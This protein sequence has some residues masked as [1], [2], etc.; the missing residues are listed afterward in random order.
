MRATRSQFVAIGGNDVYRTDIS[1]YAKKNGDRLIPYPDR[2]KHFVAKVFIQDSRVPLDTH[3][4]EM[5]ETLCF[6]RLRSE[7]W[8]IVA[9]R[10]RILR[11]EATVLKKKYLM[12]SDDQFL[13]QK[14]S[15]RKTVTIYHPKIPQ[16]S[17][18]LYSQLITCQ[19]KNHGKTRNIALRVAK[20]QERLRNLG[21][22]LP[23]VPTFKV[24]HF[25]WTINFMEFLEVTSN[26]IYNYVVL[27][28]SYYT[29]LYFGLKKKTE[30]SD[31]SDS[32]MDTN[33]TAL[34]NESQLPLSSPAL[35]KSASASHLLEEELD[36]EPGEL[37][38]EVNRAEMIEGAVHV[39]QK[40]KPGN[41]RKRASVE[42]IQGR[43]T[44]P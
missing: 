28:T 3:L 33:I 18:R 29:V 2:G 41:V 11:D 5:A 24:E 39:I 4:P 26:D 8:T 22:S 14:V 43:R 38:S 12:V 44:G 16:A 40:W 31:M 19:G 35:D 21:S 34:D 13:K 9:K 7:E 17:F 10:H 42:P 1:K 32:N 36:Y 23:S 20:H 30:F 37:D 27:R 15:P 25:K 6:G